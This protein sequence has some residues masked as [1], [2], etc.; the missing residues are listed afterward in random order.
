MLEVGWLGTVA[1]VSAACDEEEDCKTG[2]VV[3]T[4][5]RRLERKASRDWQM[6]TVELA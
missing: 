6:M 4:A 5:D 2:N 1:S 3:D